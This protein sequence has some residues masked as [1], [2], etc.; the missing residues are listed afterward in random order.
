MR[1]KLDSYKAAGEEEMNRK[2]ELTRSRAPVSK[3]EE[4]E[5]WFQRDRRRRKKEVEGEAFAVLVA[6]A[7]LQ[8]FFAPSSPLL[9]A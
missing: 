5:T 9:F 2:H 8:S 4:E 3:K 7:A 6:A 1:E